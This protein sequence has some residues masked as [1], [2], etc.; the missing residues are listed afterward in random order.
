MG[1]RGKGKFPRPKRQTEQVA[2]SFRD[3]ISPGNQTARASARTNDTKRHDFP[4]GLTP[5]PPMLSIVFDR[6]FLSIFSAISVIFCLL[7]SSFH[8]LSSSFY[9]LSSIFYFLSSIFYFLCS[10]VHLRSSIFY[11]LSSIVYRLFFYLS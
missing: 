9:L 10:I 8:H 11:S 6:L 2:I 5:Q 7:S 1:G 4:V 3:R